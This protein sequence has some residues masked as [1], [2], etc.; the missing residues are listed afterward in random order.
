MFLT[1]S[2]INSGQVVKIGDFGL[3]RDLHGQDYYRVEDKHRP[4]PVKWMAIESLNLGKFSTKSDV[5]SPEL[6]TIS[7]L[8]VNVRLSGYKIT[9]N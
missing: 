8:I 6:A 4:L 1:F 2:R 9:T 5:V 3:S 7:L